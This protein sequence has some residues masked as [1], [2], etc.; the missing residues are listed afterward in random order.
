MSD[1]WRSYYTLLEKRSVSGVQNWLGEGLRQGRLSNLLACPCFYCIPVL[2]A[3]LTSFFL[4]V[5]STVLIPVFS[6]ALSP[7]P[8]I[9]FLPVL[10]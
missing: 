9:A 7:V 8:L 3:V 2:L 5:L 10:S 4:P 6:L 1:Y